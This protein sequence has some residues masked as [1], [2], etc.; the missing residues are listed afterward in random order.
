MQI[1]SFQYVPFPDSSL[2]F[3][4]VTS[5]RALIKMI[6][7]LQGATFLIITYQNASFHG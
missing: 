1:Q 4:R 7:V 3:F 6:F 5:L 2:R